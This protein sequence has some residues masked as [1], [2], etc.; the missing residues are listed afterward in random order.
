MF[1][2][3]S[4]APLLTKEVLLPA[5]S[6]PC[7]AIISTRLFDIETSLCGNI[8]FKVINASLRVSKLSSPKSSTRFW[9]LLDELP[10]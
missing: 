1:W 9:I 2:N 8:A 5:S 6:S 7:S 10:P 3:N 4:I